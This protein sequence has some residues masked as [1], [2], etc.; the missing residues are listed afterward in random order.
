MC[1]VDHIIHN[2]KPYVLEVNGSPGSGAEY[3]GYIYKDFYSDAEP[4]GKIDGEEMMSNIIDWVSDRAHWDRQSLLECGW[5]ETVDLDDIGKVRQNLIQVTVR[6]LRALHADE[7]T[8]KRKDIIWK[9]D[10]KTFKK[11]RHGKK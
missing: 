6:K 5:L 1:G 8:E 7:I 11:P 4:G 3:E 2:N 10:G 9:Y